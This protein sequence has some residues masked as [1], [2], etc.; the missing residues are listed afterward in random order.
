ME[1]VNKRIISRLEREISRFQS[2]DLGIP[3]IQAAVLAHGH[4]VEG[5]DRVWHDLVDHVEGRIDM[6]RFTVDQAGQK[7]K[8]LGV[9]GELLQAAEKYSR[10]APQ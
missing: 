7:E 10:D 1:G 3:E 2:G 5:A 6:I 8:V 4:A 9:V